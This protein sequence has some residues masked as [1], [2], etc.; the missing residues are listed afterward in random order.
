MADCA[1]NNPHIEALLIPAAG[2]LM[3]QLMAVEFL[4]NECKQFAVLVILEHPG[5]DLRRLTANVP[6]ASMR[7]L[8]ARDLEVLLKGRMRQE[9]SHQGVVTLRGGD[10]DSLKLHSPE[11]PLRSAVG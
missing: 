2:K 7:H 8:L 10:A 6:L 5:N 11:T 3:F 4:V 1:R 9:H